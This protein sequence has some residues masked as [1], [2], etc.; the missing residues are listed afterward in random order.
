[1]TVN[2]AGFFKRLF[3]Y[4]IDG[5]VLQAALVLIAVML[6]ARTDIPPFDLL[7]FQQSLA[8]DPVAAEAQ[9]HVLLTAIFDPRLLI[10]LIIVSALYN[11]LMVASP[12]QA[13]LGKH[14]YHLRVVTRQGA[15]LNLLQSTAR[16]LACLV[17][18]APFMLGFLLP[19]AHREKAALHDVIAS[20]QVIQGDPT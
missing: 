17:S 13:T 4:C 3:A 11:I 10:A 14:Y 1:M 16:H 7:T 8:S 18:F 6:P 9:L 19:L 15:R 5:V 12:W 2:Y 20:T